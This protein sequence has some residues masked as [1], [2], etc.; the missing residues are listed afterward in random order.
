[1]ISKPSG[2]FWPHRSLDSMIPA[3]SHCNNRNFRVRA[4]VNALDLA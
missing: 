1:M 4:F 2:D 3:I